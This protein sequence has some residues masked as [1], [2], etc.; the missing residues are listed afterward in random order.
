MEDVF[1]ES[2]LVLLKRTVKSF[3][4]EQVAVLEQSQ[5]D[6]LQ[7]LP[8]EQVE[9]L[10][11]KAR[12]AGLFALGAKEEWG[13]AG[14][15]LFIRSVIYEE[16]AKHRLGLYHP[17]ADAFG[18]ELPSFLEQCTLEQ[19]ETYVK[20][21][22]ERG[23]GCFMALWEALEDNHIERLRCEAV[24]QGADWVINGHKSYIQKLEQSS[25]GIILVNCLGDNGAK[26]ATLFILAPTDSYELKETVL[27]DVQTRHEVILKD[28]RLPDD[29]R[30]GKVG[31]GAQLIKQWLAETQVL[32]GARCLGV[33]EKA[34]QYA[35]DYAMLRIT[36]GKALIEFPAVQTMIA[37]AVLNI[38]AARLMVYDAAK[39]IDAGDKDGRIS[40][41][42]AKLF[43]TEAAAKII[44]DSLQICGGSGYAGDLPIE[45]WYKEIRLARVDLQKKETILEEIVKM[46]R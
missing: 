39:Q 26:E 44:D 30:I 19:I 17:A 10:K 38:K 12:M 32:L 6:Y 36:R 5:K 34:L 2:D 7:K 46:N 40:A 22:I 42:M 4:A 1:V 25:F 8:V 3:V 11:E 21:A 14:L 24:K 16:A 18:E 33:A 35:R 43:A 28:V 29:R 15:S 9:L 27:M 41:K 31:E 37:E 13:G 20:P 23:K 45:R